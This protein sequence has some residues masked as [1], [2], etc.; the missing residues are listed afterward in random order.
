MKTKITT[1][2]ALLATAV[3]AFAEPNAEAA[4]PAP[5]KTQCPQARPGK[6]PKNAEA[7]PQARGHRG[8]A[9]SS[10]G[11]HARGPQNGPR[12]GEFRGAFPQVRGHRGDEAPS[13]N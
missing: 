3:F 11:H 12:G 4:K 7:R 2:L 13:R 6:A 1:I 5:E 10:F 9:G 8:D